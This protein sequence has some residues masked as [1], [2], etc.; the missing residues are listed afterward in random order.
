MGQHG[1]IAQW[2]FLIVAMSII[3]TSRRLMM[4]VAQWICLKLPL[5]DIPS[6]EITVV[7]RL[8]DLLVGICKFQR[9]LGVRRQ[10]IIHWPRYLQRRDLV[11]YLLQSI[12]AE[13]GPQVHFIFFFEFAPR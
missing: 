6:G 8:M 7:F 12:I 13:N 5:T 3:R 1:G 11:N 4:V 10:P 9:N 2:T